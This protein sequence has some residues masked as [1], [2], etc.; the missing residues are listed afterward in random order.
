MSL[1]TRKQLHT[2][3]WT[4]L[5]IND[6][7]ISG[8]NYFATKQKQPEITKGYTIFEWSPGIPITDKDNKTQS[9][10]DEIYSTHEDENDDDITENGE[11]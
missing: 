7:V 5:T 1:A 11:D 3:I 6:Q 10:E 9:E 2:F 4:E 8:V